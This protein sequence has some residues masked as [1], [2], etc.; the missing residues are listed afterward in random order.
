[1]VNKRYSD[2][3]RMKCLI[4]IIFASHAHNQIITILLCPKCAIF[5]K[6][7]IL[8]KRSQLRAN[9]VLGNSHQAKAVS[10]LLKLL[11]HL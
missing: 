7:D 5:R 3:N 4:L 2:S 9:E 6:S 10:L 1:M 8:S 11:L